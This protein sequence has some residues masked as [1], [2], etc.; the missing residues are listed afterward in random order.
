MGSIASAPR[1]PVTR[2]EFDA[3]W[4]SSKPSL[5]LDSVADLL[6]Q[7]AQVGA[8][9]PRFVEPNALPPSN[10]SSRRRAISS[11]PTC[12]PRPTRAPLT[13]AKR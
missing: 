10:A 12:S 2:D 8:S 13:D 3:L 9:C 11:R 6:W 1:V 7:L 4:P 5:P